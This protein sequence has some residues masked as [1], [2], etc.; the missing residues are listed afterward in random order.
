MERPTRK[1][2]AQ[3]QMAARINKRHSDAVRE[4]IQTSQLVNVLQ[5]HALN[6]AGEFPPTRMKAIEILL[7]KSLPDLSAVEMTGPDGDAIQHAIKV[8]FKGKSGA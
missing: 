3:T 2:V 1:G 8:T 5:D 6:G 7:K 4:R